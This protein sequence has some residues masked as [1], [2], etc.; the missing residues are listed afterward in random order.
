MVTVNYCLRDAIKHNVTNPC[1][2]INWYITFKFTILAYI[3]HFLISLAYI[4]LNFEI[5]RYLYHIHNLWYA[6]DTSLP[7][8][9]FLYQIQHQLHSRR[10][11]IQSVLKPPA[12]MIAMPV[13]LRIGFFC[14]IFWYISAYI[15][16]I[17]KLMNIGITLTPGFIY[18]IKRN[19]FIIKQN[20]VW[21]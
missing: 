20:A 3:C 10:D 15:V 7:D 21:M 6:Y 18:G 16:N 19:V 8:Q 12:D 13:K 5:Y 11:S 14:K 9:E 1:R 17:I 2:A 4:L